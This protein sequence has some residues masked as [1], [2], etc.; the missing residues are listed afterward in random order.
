MKMGVKRNHVNKTCYYSKEEKYT[1]RQFPQTASPALILDSYVVLL[2]KCNRL[3]RE[4]C[5]AATPF[6]IQTP[7]K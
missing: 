6:F 7:P 4:L 5:V 1:Q 3:S 2:K